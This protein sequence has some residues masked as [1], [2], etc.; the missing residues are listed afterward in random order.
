MAKEEKQQLHDQISKLTD[1]MSLKYV[2]FEEDSKDKQ[3][4]IA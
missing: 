1:E 3:L 2:E 4:Q